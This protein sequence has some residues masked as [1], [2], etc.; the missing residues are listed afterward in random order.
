M[1]TR[2]GWVGFVSNLGVACGCALAIGLAI[3]VASPAF[4]TTYE[5]DANGDEAYDGYINGQHIYVGDLVVERADNLDQLSIGRTNGQGNADTVA[6]DAEDHD[7]YMEIYPAAVG[8]GCDLTY[9]TDNWGTETTLAMVYIGADGNNDVFGET[10]PGEYF[11]DDGAVEFYFECYGPL[12]NNDDFLVY[13]PGDF[14]NFFWNVE[15]ACDDNDGDGF[16]NPGDP[17]CP[18]GEDDD[19]DDADADI[20]PDGVEVL[21]GEDNDCDGYYDNGVLPDGALVVT[22]VMQNPLAVGDSAG[23]WFEVYNDTNVDL[24]LDGLWVY[25][26][27]S[28]DFLVSGD[29]IVPAGGYIVFGANDDQGLN[30]GVPVDYDYGGFTLGNSDDEIYLEHDGTVVDSIHWDNGA[31][32]PDPEGAAMSLDP[33]YLDGDNDDGGNWCEAVDA[34]GD[35]DLGTPAAVNPDCCEDADGDGYGDEA[36]GG[37][38]CDD[39]DADVNPGAPEVCDGVD[40]DCDGLGYSYTTDTN[41]TPDLDLQMADGLRG[42]RWLATEAAELAAFDA[43]VDASP[44]TDI[45][46]E[47]YE[48]A[49]ELSGYLLVES[50]VSTSDASGWAWHESGAMAYTLQSG[51]YY[52]FAIYSADVVGWQLQSAAANPAA[53]SFG[54][55][56][57][58]I[59]EDGLGGAPPADGTGF[60]HVAANAVYLRIHTD[61]EPDADGDGYYACEDCDDDDDAINPG[62]DEVCDGADN[63]CDQAVDED[64]IDETTWYADT[65]GDGYGDA[66]D[67][68]EA[69]D[70]PQDYVANDDDC[71]DADATVNPAASEVCDDVDNDCDGDIDGDA[72]DASTWYADSDGDSYGDASVS[73]DACDQPQDYVANDDDCDDT[74]AAINPAATE[75]CDGEDND[76]D[77]DAD[78]DDAADASTWYLDQ[79]GDGFG[80]PNVTDEACDQPQGYAATDDD[81][82]DNDAAQY[83]GA[84]ELCNAEDDDCDGDVDE[85]AVDDTVWYADTDGDGFGDPDDS[86]E[87]CDQPQ[88]H[89]ANDDDCDDTD[90]AINPAATEVCDDVDNDCDG[91][92]DGDA[93]DADTWYAD[94]DGDT[95]GDASVTQEACDQ[96]Q[97]HVGNDEDCDDTDAAINPAATEVCDGEDNDC[98]GDVDEDDAAD[99]STWYL[100]QDDDGFGIPNVTDE[101][102][103][104]PQGYAAN[105]DDCDDN[106]ADIHPGADEL[107][108]AEDDDCDGDVDEDA[109]DATAWYADADGDGY[110]DPAVSQEACDQ[111]QDHVANDDDCDDGDANQYPGVDELCNGEDDDCDG[112]V[113]EEAIDGTIWYVD[114]DEDGYG[115]ANVTETACDQPDGYVDNL[116]DCDDADADIHPGADEVCDQVD[117]DCDGDVDEDD[118]LDVLTWYADAD[119]DG[120]GDPAVTVEDCYEPAGHVGNDD[121]CDDTDADVY[122][123]A[124]EYCD[125]V[126]N[127]CDGDVDEDDALDVLTWYRDADGDT[128]GTPDLTAEACDE[129]Q[130]F[131]DNPDDCDDADPNVYPGA[132]ELHDGEDQDCDGEVDEGVL[133]VGAL[134]VTEIMQN[135]DAVAD[136]VGEWFEVYND[137]AQPINLFGLEVSDAGTN[138]FVVDEDVWVAP[139]EH[140][141]MGCEGDP[142]VNGGVDL[143]YVYPTD[144]Q[145]ANGDDEIYLDH[146]GVALDAV[147]YLGSDPWPDPTGQSSSLDPTAYD[148]AANDDGDNWCATHALA[149]Y[150]I[151][152]GDHAT[153]GDE[154][155][156]CCLDLDGDGYDDEACGG[157]DCDDGDADINPGAAEVCDGV[158]QDCDGLADDGFDQDGDGFTTC[159][160]DCDD[161][162]GAVNPV[163]TD[164]CNGID[165]DCD[166]IVDNG[167]DEDADGWTP[168]PATATTRTR[169]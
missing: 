153:P 53:H 54:E 39:A 122:P 14:V 26:L 121:D 102:C 140:A 2:R 30:G 69:C 86:Q 161:G 126:D 112:D 18:G 80:N 22:E 103:D 150:Q 11:G 83:P 62:A 33:D 3:G 108:N 65:D 4:A 16:G 104:Q 129:P 127:D 132:P 93:V 136:D 35:G 114:G 74:D 98:D 141:V 36:C 148:E 27:D 151:D 6:D 124:D 147:E 79:D 167:Y 41:E 56:Q 85:D 135:P 25:D 95:Y 20:H 37:E 160:G 19:C 90:A 125:Q 92:I 115:D 156:D 8:N 91:D 52:V 77:G 67:S 31:T 106:D 139:G 107:C 101:A 12:P 145:L 138:L 70:Q 63:D 120:Y 119:Q 50:T 71:D 42:G 152:G 162:D 55:H 157:D 117:N 99:V 154:N 144:F 131:T 169:R 89:A 149:E 166:G 111:P 105:G 24:N 88:D 100:D 84:D 78:E 47:L 21:D 58:A 10:I 73:Q 34:Y 68:Q 17:S 72:V 97:D 165:D 59:I 159:G 168:A 49:Q 113:D 38:D 13:V 155:P 96:P 23:E 109:V 28:D 29:L 57:A 164:L 137:T 143:D 44:G 94:S 163:A 142:A 110:G 82:D 75:V 7:V 64:A 43:Y 128:Y 61:S 81:C 87:A 9:S 76:C 60:I 40:N 51:M 158:D 66:D 45:I 133:P 48:S 116:D 15:G 130:G 32:W 5:D 1:V 46:F 134:L 146:G 118:A 123:G